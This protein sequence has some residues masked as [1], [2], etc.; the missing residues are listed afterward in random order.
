MIQSPL[1]I[2]A[3]LLAVLALLFWAAR[4]SVTERLFRFIPLLV[5][6]YFVPTLLSNT[7]VIPGDA[8]V[9]GWVKSYLLPASLILMTLAAD[10]PSMLRLGRNVLVLFFSATISIVIG[11]PL[12]YLALGW[13]VPPEIG[14]QAWRGLAALSGSWIGGGANFLAIGESVGASNEIIGLMV[15]VDVAVANVWMATLLYFA[16]RSRSMDNAIGADRDSLEELRTRVQAYHEATSRAPVTADMMAIAA[17]AIG[18]TVVA[19]ALAPFL[20][21]T[22]ITS[23]FIWVVII[24]TTIGMA[25][26]F[27]PVRKLDGAGASAVGAV[28]LYLL[29]TTIGASAD[30]AGVI[31]ARALVLVGALWMAFH[32]AIMLIIRRL[33]RA[34]IFFAAVGSQ[35][36]VGG[37]AS[38]PVVAAAF[39]PSLAPVG[40]LLAVGGYV[41]GTYAALGCA[42]LL[43]LVHGVY[44]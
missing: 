5:F 19:H 13:M 29:V 38:A 24:A 23:Q 33:L 40:V 42:Y 2:V 7:G 27:T 21:E 14:D 15:V 34:P 28:F 36:N 37:A 35:A 16:G 12:A 4:W 25:L 22:S 44:F 17:I 39:H 1:A 9:Y 41:L 31:E 43:E 26:S 11:G 18:G 6:A 8:E 10:I 20:P 30:F 3:V 32:A